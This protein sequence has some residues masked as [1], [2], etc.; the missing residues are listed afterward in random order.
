MRKAY[1]I[2]IS[3]ATGSGKSTFSDTLKKHLS[4]YK[5][6]VIHMDEYYKE[7][8]QRPKIEGIG[9]GKEYIDDNHPMALELEQCY[10]DMQK[11]INMDYDIVMV[12]GIFAFWDKR[13]F[14]VLDLKIFIDCDS[15]ERLVRRILRNLSFGQKLEEITGRYVQAV[16]P[17]QKE[18]VEPAKWKAD[19]ILNGFSQSSTGVEIIVNWIKASMSSGLLSKND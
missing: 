12:E 7:E 2:G 14:D 4:D 11:A 6:K 9:D 16:Q 5:V 17:R 18:Y 3:G 19:I 8:F 13:I 10:M 1:A 15:D